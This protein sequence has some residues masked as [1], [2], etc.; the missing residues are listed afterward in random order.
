M[1]D[2]VV[3]VM[4][5]APPN[6]FPRD[7]MAEFFGLRARLV[8][9]AEPERAAMEHRLAELEARIRAWPRTPLNDPFHAAAHEMAAELAR[10]TGC[11][12]IV[13][14]NEFCSPTLDE[15]LDRAAAMAI[16]KVVVITPMMTRGGE[17]AEVDIPAAV[18]LAQQRHP[19]A[20]LLYAWPFDLAEVAAFLGAQVRKA[21]SQPSQ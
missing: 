19:G 5:G 14:F 15:A 21:L 11:E 16:G 17:H 4:H 2:V 12:V 6:D 10:A 18:R 3:L 8:R 13:G 9:A 1:G 7:E 20:Q